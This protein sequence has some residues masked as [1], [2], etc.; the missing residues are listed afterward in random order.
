MAVAPRPAPKAVSVAVREGD[1][2]LLAKSFERSLLAAN[3]SPDTIRIYTI[4]VA[5]LAAFLAERGMPLTVAGVARQHL[6]EWLTDILRRRSP[7]TA[8]TR[9]R[10]AKAF[11]D[12]LVDDGALK[13]SPLAR[14]KRPSVPEQPPPML[15]DDE[16]RR[17]LKT[18][19]G[20]AFHD[21]RDV[22]ILRLFVDT[23]LR[24]SELARAGATPAAPRT[25]GRRRGAAALDG[26]ARRHRRRPVPSF[27]EGVG[28]MPADPEH[29]K[30]SMGLEAGSR[31]ARWRGSNATAASR[32]IGRP[33]PG[34]RSPSSSS[35]SA[36]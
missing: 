16:L 22:A 18:C 6:E 36:T 28:T 11:F 4:S 35:R 7:A 33:P 2:A 9:Y 15:S 27:P 13:E 34:R 24:R 14:V 29:A 25:L 32:A 20:G 23:G 12:W 26:P 17:L 31:S 21:R 3:R 10:G 8:E 5:Q 30:R 19:E 1:F